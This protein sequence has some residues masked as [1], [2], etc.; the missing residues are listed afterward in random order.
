MDDLP[1]IIIFPDIVSYGD[2]AQR[3][4]ARLEKEGKAP[5]IDL[6]SLMKQ[7]DGEEEAA[8]KEGDKDDDKSAA[9]L[10]KNLQSEN[11]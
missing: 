4:Q 7:P 5:T 10:L 1:I 8:E 11:K 6:D 2:E 9:D 3:E